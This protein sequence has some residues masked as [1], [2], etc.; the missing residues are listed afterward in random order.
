L[1]AQ[2]TAFAV[3]REI[4]D[5]TG[6]YR[7]DHHAG[8]VGPGVALVYLLHRQIGIGG[9]RHQRRTQAR[10]GANLDA[11]HTVDHA[12]RI[13]EPGQEGMG[14]VFEIQVG[15]LLAFDDVAAE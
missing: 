8:N 4:D 5:P 12:A 11:L 10:S 13:L 9:D 14:M 1:A 6:A 15:V 2:R 3:P 7:A